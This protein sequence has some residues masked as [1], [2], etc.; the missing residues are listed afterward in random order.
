MI[1]RP[2]R[3]T[4]F[5]YTTLFRSLEVIV[6]DAKLRVGRGADLLDDATRE[7]WMR[8]DSRAHRGAANRQFRERGSRGG[9]PANPV[10]DL[11]L[12]PGELLAQSDR[13]SIHQVGPSGLD[14]RI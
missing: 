12:I 8:V 4:L 1:R 3:S 14:D 6:R 5:P 11:G 9:H 13:S 2:P 7:V 10:I